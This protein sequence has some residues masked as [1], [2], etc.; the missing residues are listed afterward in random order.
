MSASIL[1]ADMLAGNPKAGRKM[2]VILVTLFVFILVSVAIVA[3]R[4]KISP[5]NQPPL[6]PSALLAE[7]SW[8]R[9]S[10]THTL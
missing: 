7:V 9:R 3:T 5:Q 6:H 2:W 10:L 1:A 4:K 8:S